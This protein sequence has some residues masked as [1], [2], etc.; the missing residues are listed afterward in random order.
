MQQMSPPTITLPT[1]VPFNMN[2]VTLVLIL[3]VELNVTTERKVI[4]TQVRYIIFYLRELQL[5]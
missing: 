5:K 1:N 2:F 3:I 4:V